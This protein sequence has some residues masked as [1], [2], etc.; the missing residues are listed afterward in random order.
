MPS[1]D[2]KPTTHVAIVSKNP[3]TL[4]GLGSYLERAGVPSRGARA[5][6]EPDLVWLDA[7]TAAVIFPDDFTEGEVLELFRLLRQDRP[8]LCAVLVTREPH[9][10]RPLAP[11]DEP[12]PP[13]IVLP[14]PS[15]GWDILDAIRAHAAR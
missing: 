10:F 4:D 14:R 6:A 1:P 7:A 5:L 9:R 12:A 11:A 15:F 13:T 8:R 2:P 3:E